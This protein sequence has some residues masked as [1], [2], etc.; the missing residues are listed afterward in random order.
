MKKSLFTIPN[1]LGG[2]RFILAFAL[3]AIA[4]RGEPV[5]FIAV[6]ILAFLLD[7]VDGPIARHL[8][9]Q[10][11]QGSRLDTV[12][13]FSVYTALVISV[14]LLWPAIFWK[15]IVFIGL[16]AASM[17]IPFLV[18][19]IKFH[20]FTSYHT[21]LVK[22]A[23][24]CIAAGAIILISGGPAWPFRIAS[25]IS[26][27]GGIEQILISFLLSKPQADVRHLFAVIRNRGCV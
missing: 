13:D 20:T 14:F 3:L 1:T 8:Q 12:A 19:L 11:E 2:L 10:S 4:L 26:V 17:L 23:T 5:L 27:L 15:E 6:L 22:V 21:W 9:Q 18:A 7:S 25:I 24:V 16:A